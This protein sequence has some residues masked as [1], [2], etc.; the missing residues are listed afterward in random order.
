M[1][2]QSIAAASTPGVEKQLL[3][4]ASGDCVTTDVRVY[5]RSNLEEETAIDQTA[6]CK[7]GRSTLTAD[8]SSPTELQG[9][10][11]KNKDLL[12]ASG[13]ITLKGADSFDELEADE[14]A[15]GV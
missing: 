1:V 14:Q 11:I 3:G 5:Y 12:A 7:H 13:A 10:A 9:H 15:V 6:R 4:Q 8:T 2:E